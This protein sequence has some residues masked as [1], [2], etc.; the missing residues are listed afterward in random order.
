M[1][2][3]INN[4]PAQPAPSDQGSGLG[5]GLIVGIVVVILIVLFLL[6]LLPW[7][8][9]NRAPAPAAPQEEN[10]NVDIPDVNLPDQVDVNVE[11]QGLPYAPNQQSAPSPN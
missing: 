5:V 3:V 2:T 6:F 8:G 4:P 7:W 10:I 1:A 9:T 11:G